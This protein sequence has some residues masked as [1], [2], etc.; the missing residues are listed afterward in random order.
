MPFFSLDAGEAGAAPLPGAAPLAPRP[1]AEPAAVES[2]ADRLPPATACLLP[3]VVLMAVTM[4]TGAFTSG[5]DLLYPLRVVAVAA[6]LFRL[7]KPLRWREFSI[8]P[9]AVGIGAAAFAAWMLLVPGPADPLADF[10]AERDPFL[11]LDRPWA[12]AWLACRVFGAVVTVPV[13]EELAFR[14]FLLHRLVDQDVEAVPPGRF[15]WPSFL[16]SSLAFGLL[17]GGA[18]IAATVAGLCF[19]VALHRR[20]RLADAVV[21]HATTNLLLSTYV[22]A[23]GSWSSW[24]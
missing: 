13:A 16:A 7:R 11:A 8:S 1:A 19:A 14:G 9:A 17:H 21:A 24:G 15:T 22:L 12:L 5:F 2:S 10:T 3:F 4:L 23:T 6:T 20:G 18:W